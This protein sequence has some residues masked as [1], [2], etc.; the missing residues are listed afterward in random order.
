MGGAPV[1]PVVKFGHGYIQGAEHAARELG[2]GAGEVTVNFHYLGD[3]APQPEFA[4]MAGSWF[5]S[6][7]S[8]IFAAAGSAGGNVKSAAEGNNGVVIGVDTDQAAL[9]P[10]VI[11]SA[12]KGLAVSVYDLLVAY[13]N[14]NFVGGRIIAYS[15]AN[16][17]IALPMASSRFQS[18]TQAQYDAVYAQLAN[19]SIRVN[20]TLDMPEVVAGLTIVTVE[21]R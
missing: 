1:P 17:G 12:M 19:G 2:L 16:N 18:F 5:T 3:F 10:T 15:A 14:D 11:T 7:T 21:V 4:V 6:G 13:M 8:V 9:S 20:G